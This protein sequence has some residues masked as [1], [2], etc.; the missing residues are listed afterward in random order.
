MKIRIY[1]YAKEG[2]RIT[3]TTKERVLITRKD[4]GKKSHK[5]IKQHYHK[6]INHYYVKLKDG[7]LRRWTQKNPI[8]VLDIRDKGMILEGTGK[9]LCN[10]IAA[11]K[12]EWIWINWEVKS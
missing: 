12:E 9:E 6:N 3:A 2:N 10:Q 8:K 11:L 4:K 7:H 1:G 5:R